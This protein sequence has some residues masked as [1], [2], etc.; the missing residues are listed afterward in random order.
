MVSTLDVFADNI[1]ISVNTLVTLKKPRARKLINQ[2]L[3]LLDVNKKMLS[4]KWELP[5]Q[6]TKQ[7]GQVLLHGIV[8]I[9]GGGMKKSIQEEQNPSMIGF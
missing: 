5:K 3:A 4:A 7:Y 1:P 8:Y 2:L 6:R 9:S